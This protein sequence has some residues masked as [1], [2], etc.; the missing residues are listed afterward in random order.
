MI[1]KIVLIL[2]ILISMQQMNNTNEVVFGGGCFWCTEAIFKQ[3]DGV[4]DVSPG[5]SGGILENPTYEE[6]C[7]GETGHAEVVRIRYNPNEIDFKKLLEVFFLTHDPTT[8]NRQ[9]A[10]RGTQYRSVVFYTTPDQKRITLEIIEKLNKSKAYK[11]Q[12]VTEVLPLKKFYL[13]EDYHQNYFARNKNQP[14][15]QFVIQP[16]MDKFKETFGGLIKK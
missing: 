14:Y 10:D 6:V 16:K 9:G 7:D 15:C 2:F 12:I 4:I 5:Y 1:M 11:N 13:A 3:L 8:L